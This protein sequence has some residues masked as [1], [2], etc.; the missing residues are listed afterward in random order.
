MSL[1]FDKLEVVS[2]FNKI[3]VRET[4]E[5]GKYWRR[6]LYP[7]MDVSSEVQEIKDTAEELWTDE[8]KASW[9]KHLEEKQAKMEG[10]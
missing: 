4:D 7:D 5:N 9:T 10:E 6:I 2:E 8:V 1:N 3:Q